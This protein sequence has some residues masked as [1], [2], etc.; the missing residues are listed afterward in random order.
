MLQLALAAQRLPK[1]Q[2]GSLEWPQMALSQFNNCILFFFSPAQIPPCIISPKQL[3]GPLFPVVHKF[4]Y[5]IWFLVKQTFKPLKEL[6]D[7]PLLPLIL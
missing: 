5:P 2:I 1:N 4:M 7:A 6:H 3:L